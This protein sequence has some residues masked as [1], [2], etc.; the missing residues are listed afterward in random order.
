MNKFFKIIGLI[1]L[2]III[3]ITFTILSLIFISISITFSNKPIV[4]NNSFLLIDFNGEIKE[5]PLTKQFFP[6]KKNKQIELIKYLK[7]IEMAS[8]DSKIESI[9]INADITFYN[10]VHAREIIS[11]IEKFKK[12]GKKVYAWFSTGINSN[13]YLACVADY[14]YM[15]PTNSATLSLT[16]S[17]FSIPYFKKTFDKIGIKFNVFNIGKY[18]GTYENFSKDEISEE[19]KNSY[20]LFIKNINEDI[21]ETISLYRNID[22]NTLIKKISNGETILIPPQKAKEDGFIDDLL[23]YE[24]FI[25]KVTGKN[26]K[27][28]SISLYSELLKEKITE[29]KIAII[30]IEGVITNSW[31]SYN[32]INGD[33]VGAKSFLKDLEEIKK[34]KGIKAII[35]RVNSPGG[36]ALGSELILNGLIQIKSTIPVYVSMGPISASGGYYISSES[37]RIFA[38]NATITGSIGVVFMSVNTEKLTENLGINYNTLK[39]YKY[40]DFLNP[41][42]ELTEKEKEIILNSMKLTY[43]EFISHV[44]KGRNI[45]LEKISEI[46][47]GRIWTGKDA[48]KHNLIDE[49]GG[50]NEVIEYAVMTNEIKNY[51]IVSYPKPLNFWEELLNSENSLFYSK[52][53][54]DKLTG[55]LYKKIQNIINLYKENNSNFYYLL[56]FFEPVY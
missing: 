20:N 18:K 40:D 26:S 15:P 22:K 34:D 55:N 7:A 43:D 30:Y 10:R 52:D 47:E 8:Y 3:G 39:Q 13:Y 2:G 25:K 50:L 9:I 48:L 4:Y 37:D 28:I 54:L 44:L 46:A 24:D 5:K 31:N 35:L 27:P 21:I 14:I 36:S 33:M 23:T 49:I 1:F 51:S 32:K 45:P 16:G 6:F 42:R 17:Y 11:S 38:S 56:P 19:L 41:M 29:N 12:S 53:I